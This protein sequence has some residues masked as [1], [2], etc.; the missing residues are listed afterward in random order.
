MYCS[1]PSVAHAAA[2]AHAWRLNKRDVPSSL[3]EPS[4][5]KA[6]TLEHC[7][8]GPV[9]VVTLVVFSRLWRVRQG[10]VQFCTVMQYEPLT[11][12]AFSDETLR[13]PKLDISAAVV[14]RP[15]PSPSAQAPDTYVAPSTREKLSSS[16]T[17]NTHVAHDHQ[18]CSRRSFS[19]ESTV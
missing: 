3:I 16:I 11:R 5:V 9:C 10:L 8:V 13:C 19:F 17:M 18:N 7:R 2:C 14:R 15:A 4:R 6:L 12:R 1:T